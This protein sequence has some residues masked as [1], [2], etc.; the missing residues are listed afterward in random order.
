MKKICIFLFTGTGMTAYVIDK[1]K[2]E[3][4]TKQ[5]EV[6]VFLIEDTRAEQLSYENY[7]GIGLAFPVHS[8]NAP[9]IVMKF[10]KKL[11][12]WRNK[13]DQSNDPEPGKAFIINVTG[14]VSPMNAAATKYVRRRLGKKGFKVIFDRQ[15]AM[16]PNFMVKYDEKKLKNSLKNIKEQ[17]PEAADDLLQALESFDDTDFESS[18]KN[19]SESNIEN[20]VVTSAEHKKAL[21]SEVGFAAKALTFFGRAEWPGAKLMGKFLRIDKSCSDC[22]ICINYCPNRNIVKG[23]KGIKF[24]MHCGLCMRCLFICPSKSIKVRRPFRFIDFDSWYDNDELK[25][26]K[27]ISKKSGY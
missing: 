19:N 5:H 9:E 15:L 16:A 17:I 23:K 12:E 25:I 3:L 13:R 14:E 2:S 11:P 26:L 24:K 18:K 22:G 4:E 7:D 20:D 8:F 10:V 1:L 27:N 21:N 6:D